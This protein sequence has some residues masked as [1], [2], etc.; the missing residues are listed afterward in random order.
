MNHMTAGLCAVAL[1]VA[2]ALSTTVTAQPSQPQAPRR[3]PA[4]QAADPHAVHTT[5]KD[6]K[7]TWPKGDRTRGRQVFTKFECYACHEVEGEK[8]PT[9]TEKDKLGPELS[10]MGPAHEPEYFAES[11]I[12]PSAVVEKGKG[13]E[14]QDG[15]SKMPSFNDSMAVQELIDLVAYLRS[16]QPPSKAPAPVHRGH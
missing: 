9:P 5:P 1:V 6:W 8:F 13:Y 14:A 7:L 15:S 11:L 16:L 10:V 3:P 4:D 12:S 2:I